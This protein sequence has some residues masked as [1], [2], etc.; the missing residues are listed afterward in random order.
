MVEVRELP[1]DVPPA[2]RDP[3][4]HLD[5]FGWELAHREHL[6]RGSYRELERVLGLM[7]VEWPAGRHALKRFYLDDVPVDV[8]EELL[9]RAVD[10]VA[11]R[12]RSARVPPWLV[13]PES[14][15]LTVKGLHARGLSAG[16]IARRLG[17]PKRRVKELLAVR[18]SVRRP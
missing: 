8:P 1:V 18:P 10:W 5:A 17:I 13:A 12:M 6:R 4:A 16:A 2:P 14:P 11:S 7:A 9:E 3:D 15:E